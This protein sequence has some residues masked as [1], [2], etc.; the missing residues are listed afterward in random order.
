MHG[1][2]FVAGVLEDPVSW[3][4]ADHMSTPIQPGS[5]ARLQLAS[6]MELLEGWSRDADDLA[7]TAVYE[8]LFSI[9]EGSVFRD[10]VVVD[11]AER[12]THFF[13]LAGRDLAV[14]VQLLSLDTCAVV[15]IGSA[16]AAPGLD[17]AGSEEASPGR[18]A[19]AGA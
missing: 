3:R 6:G 9:T 7:K 13:V 10:H 1:R 18:D 17:R 4:K 2:G 19:A 15:Y 8:V 14:K 12:P 5:A 16:C 11:D